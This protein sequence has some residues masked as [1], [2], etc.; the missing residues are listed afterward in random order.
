[1]PGCQR[2]QLRLNAPVQGIED[3]ILR[4]APLDLKSTSCAYCS[5]FGVPCD[6]SQETTAGQR[7]HAFGCGVN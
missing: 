7:S 2:C 6:G 3:N 1:M 5:E 4:S